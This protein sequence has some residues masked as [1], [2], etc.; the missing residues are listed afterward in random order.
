MAT[1]PAQ[2]LMVCF[3]LAIAA[4]TLKVCLMT[5]FLVRVPLFH[6]V[7]CLDLGHTGQRFGQLVHVFLHVVVHHECT[8]A[9]LTLNTVLQFSLLKVELLMVYTMGHF[10]KKLHMHSAIQFRK[11]ER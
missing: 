11:K 10:K 7:L 2:T 6:I 3:I 8:W 9:K 5:L 4:V 1:T